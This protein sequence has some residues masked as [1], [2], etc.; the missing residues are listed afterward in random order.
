MIRSG[1]MIRVWGL[2]LAGM[3]LAAP[4]QA[5]RAVAVSPRPDEVALTIYQDPSP[6][7][8]YNG[9]AGLALVTE[10]RTIEV[11]AGESKVSFEGVAAGIVPATAALDGLPADVAERN[12]DYNLMSPGS[13][14][15]AAIGEPVRLVRTNPR[16]GQETVRTAIVRSGPRGV[17]LEVDGGYEALGCSGDPERLVF[18]KIPDALAPEPTL[19]MV[20]RAKEGGR[21]KVR[22]TYLAVGLNWKAN[23]VANVRPD[24]KTLDLTGWITLSNDSATTFTDAPTQ[25]VAG[26][27]SRS[28]RTAAKVVSG[29]RIESACWPTG[30]NFTDEI[31]VTGRRVERAPVMAMAPPPPWSG[32][33]GCRACSR[34]V[35]TARPV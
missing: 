22:L 27:V 23:Y 13:I 3:L 34:L 35:P 15:A 18:D 19:S 1:I 33:A 16:T 32:R 2:A 10:W 31:V 26:T 29:Q 6:T 25:V 12:Q 28:W 5:Q 30:L 20:V 9:R 11:P 17:I 8:Y 24:G 14:L 4:V 7:G 21:F